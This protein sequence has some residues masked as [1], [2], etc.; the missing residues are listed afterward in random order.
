MNSDIQKL[1]EF[2]TGRSALP[3]KK[4]L[5]LSRRK[6]TEPDENLDLNKGIKRTRNSN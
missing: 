5:S 1:K 6:K 4:K 3:K 2:F